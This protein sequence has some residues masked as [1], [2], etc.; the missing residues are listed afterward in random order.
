WFAVG[1]CLSHLDY[2]KKRGEIRCEE[3]GGLR[4]YYAN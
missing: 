3:E 2:L 4:R 1:E